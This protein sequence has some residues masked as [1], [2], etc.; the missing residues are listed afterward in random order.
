MYYFKCKSK[1]CG[2]WLC[3]SVRQY[4]CWNGIAINRI[5]S[6]SDK[7][8]LTWCGGDRSRCRRRRRWCRCSRRHCKIN[9]SYNNHLDVLKHRSR[10]RKASYRKKYG[11]VWKG[12]SPTLHPVNEA[13]QNMPKC[14][15]ITA[16]VKNPVKACDLMSGSWQTVT[17]L[18]ERDSLS[19]I[20]IIIII[21][22]KGD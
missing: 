5:H 21:I 8:T 1:I 14:T 6:N 7:T 2:K 18:L 16:E 20:I 3:H 10:K 13:T 12:K 22:T 17:I 19:L 15:T 9:I 4:A 11:I